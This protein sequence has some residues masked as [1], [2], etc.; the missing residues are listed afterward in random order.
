MGLLKV[1][2]SVSRQPILQRLPILP[3]AVPAL[4]C[5]SAF[6]ICLTSYVLV[7]P[8]HPYQM[9]TIASAVKVPLIVLISAMISIFAAVLVVY[10][11]TKSLLIDVVVDGALECVWKMGIALGVFSPIVAA[12]ALT[13]NYSYTVLFSYAAFACAGMF[14]CY[15]FVKVLNNEG[16]FRPRR[17]VQFIWTLSFCFAVAQSG[18]VLRPLIGWTGQSFAWFRADQ[19]M[20]WDQ[21]RCEA[22]NAKRGGIRFPSASEMSDSKQWPC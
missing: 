20:L 16:A 11:H 1:S 9:Q 8:G 17:L 5:A 19:T 21:M 6:G 15:G 7:V 3:R 22:R 14:G 4:L 18:W 10:A 2:T 12:I 13:G